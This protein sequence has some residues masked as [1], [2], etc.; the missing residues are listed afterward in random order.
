MTSAASKSRELDA[1]CESAG[2]AR[3][4][5]PEQNFNLSLHLIEKDFGHLVTS[6]QH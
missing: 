1:V 3:P 5:A 2:Q 6:L 4:A